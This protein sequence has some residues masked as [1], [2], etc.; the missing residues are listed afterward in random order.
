MNNYPTPKAQTF[1]REL[2]RDMTDSERR[3]W[4]RLRREQL[5]AKFR[6]QHPVGNYI[7]D[8]ACLDPK[9]IVE[10]DGS[11]H[12]QG[13]EYDEV[14][15]AFF[16]RDGFVV[17]RFATDQPLRNIDGVLTVISDALSKAMPP[18]QPSPEGGRSQVKQPSSPGEGHFRS[19]T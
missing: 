1:A 7:A 10:L 14:R 5:G 16:R 19:L 2:R 15:D 17:L 12:Q 6:R 4:S 9:L 3:L 18:S 11:Q 13:V 8:F